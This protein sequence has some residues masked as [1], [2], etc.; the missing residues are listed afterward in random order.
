MT[1]YNI[2]HI[3]DTGDRRSASTYPIYTTR[4]GTSTAYIRTEVGSSMQLVTYK[5]TGT[6][7]VDEVPSDE[8]R[9]PHSEYNTEDAQEGTASVW[10]Q[11]LAVQIQ[12]LCNKYKLQT[13]QK[14]DDILRIV[15]T[16]S[17]VPEDSGEVGTA[18][19]RCI[20]SATQQ[21]ATRILDTTVRSRGDG[22]GCIPT[23]LEEERSLPIP[24]LEANSEGSAENKS[25]EAKTSGTGDTDV[26]KPILV[27]NDPED[28]PFSHTVN[29]ASEQ[30]VES[31]RLA[32]ISKYWG[33]QGLDQDTIEFLT[34]K[35]R[36]TTRK[37]Y[38]NGW[39]R[40]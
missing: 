9:P 23:R 5:P 22:S 12:E 2:N 24:A 21:T 35:T 15:D 8:E 34:K 26:D 6:P 28:E 18:Q 20:R 36:Q 1:T 29:M 31:S 27:S 10:L 7:V 19:D 37:V 13:E 14:E 16:E 30:E 40:W 3:N 11:D 38:D 32:V 25:S 4:L 39:R 33:E 17:L